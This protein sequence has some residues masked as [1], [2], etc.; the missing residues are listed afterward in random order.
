[1]IQWY[2][3]TG[4]YGALK[5]KLDDNWTTENAKIAE[6]PKIVVLPRDAVMVKGDSGSN[7]ASIQ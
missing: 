5:R 1:V 3:P 4:S 2:M 7:S 6:D